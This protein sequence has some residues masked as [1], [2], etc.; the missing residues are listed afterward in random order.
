MAAQA[1]GLKSTTS[2]SS[3]AEQVPLGPEIIQQKSSRLFIILG[4]FFV[5]NALIAELIGVKIFAWETTFGLEPLDFQLFGQPGALQSS[6][7]VLLWPIVFIMTDLLNE[8]YGRRGIRFLSYLTVG[9]IIYAFFMIY[10]AI[11]LSPADWW[12]SQNAEKGVP[13][14]QLAF[15]YTYGQGLFI[16]VGSITAF[17]VAQIVDVLTFH[18][19]KKSTGEKALW[20]RAT[21]STLVSQLV[22][23]FVVLFVAFKLGPSLVSGGADPWSWSQLA[24]VGVTQYT[25]K[26]IMAVGLTPVIYLAHYL[27]DNYFGEAADIIK[28]KAAA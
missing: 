23:S 21:G 18:R 4:G 2:A 9:L 24:A 15:Q 13:D 1:D 20:L 12:V 27:I 6:A 17:L 5:A 7:G 26:F 28:A 16:I 11:G 19:I 8:Y 10:G 14:M 25:F 22:D 3:E